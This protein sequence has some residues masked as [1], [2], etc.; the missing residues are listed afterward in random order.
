MSVSTLETGI[1]S[2]AN[3]RKNLGEVISR[4]G[5]GHERTTISKNG[6]TIAAI[7]PLE[8]LELLERLELDADRKAFQEAIDED[9][10]TRI[11]FRDYVNNA[12]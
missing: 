3:L 11:P 8:D 7:V 6:K 2:L 4:A 9:D 10:G 5:F 12:S 1:I